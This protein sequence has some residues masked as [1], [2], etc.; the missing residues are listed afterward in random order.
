[1]IKVE[2]DPETQEVNLTL[3]TVQV[4]A[5]TV[6]DKLAEIGFETEPDS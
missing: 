1:M 3:D 2:A 5:E 4:S 6:R